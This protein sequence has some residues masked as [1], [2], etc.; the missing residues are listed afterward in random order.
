MPTIAEE[1]NKESNNTKEI[2]LDDLIEIEEINIKDL[3][4]KNE[5]KDD[6]EE[7]IL[8]NLIEKDSN[9]LKKKKER[10]FD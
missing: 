7:V 6:I 5:A 9:K 10:F 3:G 2:N 8:D 4:Q 1:E